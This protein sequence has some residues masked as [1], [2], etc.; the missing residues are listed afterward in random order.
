M[1]KDRRK[2]VGESTAMI[3]GP[4]ANCSLI[5]ERI[6]Y[7]TEQGFISADQG[8]Q[9]FAAHRPIQVLEQKSR[10]PKPA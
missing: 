3:H 5:F 9:Q 1:R 4:A 6:P 7:S 2:P 10:R 8:N